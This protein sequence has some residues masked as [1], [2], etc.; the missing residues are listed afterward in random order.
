MNAIIR[1]PRAEYEDSHLG[2]QAFTFCGKNFKRTDFVVRGGL[3]EGGF[4]GCDEEVET[5]GCEKSV[6]KGLYCW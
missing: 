2:P 5:E 1:P 4:D 3:E 6:D